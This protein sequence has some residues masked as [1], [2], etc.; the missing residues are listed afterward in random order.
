M[1]ILKLHNDL[2]LSPRTGRYSRTSINWFVSLVLFIFFCTL[3]AAGEIF[4]LVRDKEYDLWL[5]SE[6]LYAILAYGGS[7]GVLDFYKRKNKVDE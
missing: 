2:L 4:E 1:G 5:P 7:M 6:V 3:G